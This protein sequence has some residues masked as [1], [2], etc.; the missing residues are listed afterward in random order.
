[1][2]NYSIYTQANESELISLIETSLTCSLLTL[3]E[4]LRIQCGIFNPVWIDGKVVLHLHKKD[5]QLAALRKQGSGSLVFQ[6]IVGLIPSYWVDPNYAG[7]ATTYYRFLQLD[8]SVRIVEGESMTPYL[9][10][11][12]ER[13]QPEKHYSDI[14][15]TDPVY[16]GAFKTIVIVEFLP[17][18][19]VSKWKLGQNKSKEIRDAVV[20]RFKEK[21]DAQSMR[22]AEIISQSISQSK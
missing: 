13:F 21:G 9:V 20:E 2:R 4:D 19:K 8:C 1:M 14:D 5:E 16:L 3:G 10:K 18:S 7:S 15:S 6:D 11:M 22:A 12:M 17:V